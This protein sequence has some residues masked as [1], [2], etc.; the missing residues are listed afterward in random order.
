MLSHSSTLYKRHFPATFPC[1]IENPSLYT[2][3]SDL[4]LHEILTGLR[5]TDY[6]RLL[7]LRYRCEYRCKWLPFQSNQP[8]WTPSPDASRVQ[9]QNP[10][11]V[12]LSSST[13]GNFPPPVAS[14]ASANDS[15]GI[16]LQ[17]MMEKLNNDMTRQGV[18]TV[19]KG[20]CAAC[21]KPIVGQVK[22]NHLLYIVFF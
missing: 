21:A 12:G 2:Y 5:I 17:E 6:S 3:S 1:W 4:Q 8:G 11:A 14:T 19:P 7:S 13:P 20:H 9:A 10:N 22:L 18:M 16:S 15:K